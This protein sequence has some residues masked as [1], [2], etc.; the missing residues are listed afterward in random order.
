M[1]LPTLSSVNHRVE[2][3]TRGLHYWNT[4]AEHA[5]EYRRH[6]PNELSGTAAPR[7]YTAQPGKFNL[8]RE[9]LNGNTEVPQRIIR[10]DRASVQSEVAPSLS[11][12]SLHLSDPDELR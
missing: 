1:Q 10:I 7:K 4:G 8:L 9:S 5:P 11:R 12:P 3:L 6:L 2:P